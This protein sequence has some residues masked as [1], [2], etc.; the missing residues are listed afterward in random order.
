MLVAAE[1][2]WHSLKDEELLAL[3]I[4]DLGLR[5][6][7]SDVKS[8]VDRL[9]DELAARGVSHV[10]VQRGPAAQAGSTPRRTPRPARP[11]VAAA[12]EDGGACTPQDIS[13]TWR[14]CSYMRFT[15]ANTNAVDQPTRMRPVR[16]SIPASSRQPGPRT[17]SPKPTVV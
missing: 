3:R 15:M 14:Q 16:P 4:C 6:E 7:L 1:P 2:S 9:Y 11:A 5:L 13:C 17:T 8:Q 12:T 10:P